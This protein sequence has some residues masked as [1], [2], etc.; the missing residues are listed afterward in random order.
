MMYKKKTSLRR[1][2]FALALVPAIGAGIAVT[3]LPSVAG[4]LESLVGTS[5]ST[6]SS[7]EAEDNRNAPEEREVFTA[8]DTEPEFPDG[9]QGLMMFLMNNMRYPEDAEKAHEQGRVIVKFIVE[10]DGSTGNFEVVKGVSESLDKE[11]V[12]VLKNMP[13]WTPGSVNGKPVACYFTLPVSFR[14]Q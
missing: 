1:R 10:K 14:L 3:S 7:T 2:L 8:V 9:M 5:L 4:V 13:K 6:P 11:A 12:R